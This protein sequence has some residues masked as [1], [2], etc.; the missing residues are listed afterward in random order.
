MTTLPD[1]ATDPRA[2][3]MFWRSAFLRFSCARNIALLFHRRVKAR[4][5]HLDIFWLQRINREVERKTIGII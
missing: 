2:P 3:A 5:I 4:L 1:C